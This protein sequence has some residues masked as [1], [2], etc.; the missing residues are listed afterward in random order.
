MIGF[1]RIYVCN[2]GFICM[3]LIISLFYKEITEIYIYCSQRSQF[4]ISFNLFV[5]N[6]MIWG[7]GE[8][9]VIS[10]KNFENIQKNYN[11]FW[12]I[13]KNLKISGI[14]L[15]KIIEILLKLQ[16][17]LKFCRKIWEDLEN[18]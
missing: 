13:Y 1:S 14:F 12:K 11:T 15:E 10:L 5:L 2:V 16:E 17:K 9:K 3:R 4:L 18:H 6:D 7:S 8:I